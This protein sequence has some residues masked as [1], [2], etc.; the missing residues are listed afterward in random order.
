MKKMSY[1]EI[2]RIVKFQELHG[3]EMENCIALRNAM[4]FSEMIRDMYEQM[5]GIYDGRLWQDLF[6]RESDIWDALQDKEIVIPGDVLIK[7]S[8]ARAESKNGVPVALCMDDIAMLPKDEVPK[9]W[10]IQ[11]NPIEWL[12]SNC[13]LEILQRASASGL[14][15]H[16]LV[17]KFTSNL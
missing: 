17:E 4:E 14:S 13:D 11:P 8:T 9:N 7:L 3:M 1:E 2:I 10:N 16:P 12:K 6:I 15:K 5:G